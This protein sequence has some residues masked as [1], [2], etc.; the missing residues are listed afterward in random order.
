MKIRYKCTL[1]IL[2]IL[3]TGCGKNKSDEIKQDISMLDDDVN[4]GTDAVEDKSSDIPENLNYEVVGTNGAITVSVEAYVEAEGYG[5]ADVYS[6]KP[7][8]INSE[9]LMSF[10]KKIFDDETY[11]SIKPYVCMDKDELS[12]EKEFWESCSDMAGEEYDTYTD[13]YIRDKK[14]DIL[15][16]FLSA[17]GEYSD[18]WKQD[19]VI[20]IHELTD[21]DSNEGASYVNNANLRGFI[22]GTVYEL[23]YNAADGFE[24]PILE[25]VNPLYDN[26]DEILRFI[27]HKHSYTIYGNNPV[28][29]ETAKNDAD[30]F[31]YKLGYE[32]M[33]LVR[34]ANIQ[35]NDTTLDGYL[36]VYTRNKN[37]VSSIDSKCYTQIDGYDRA[38][39]QEYIEIYVNEYG[40]MCA[41]LMNIYELG[42]IMGESTPLLS[43]EQI[44]EN[45]KEYI[46]AGIDNE[47]YFYKINKVKFGY[48]SVCYGNS[49]ALIPAWVYQYYEDTFDDYYYEIAINAIDG[50]LINMEYA[51]YLNFY[52]D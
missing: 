39:Y 7:V 32:D 16:S 40:I 21:G 1:V 37:G 5:N 30:D 25:L 26:R 4:T 51:E 24:T 47:D 28:D 23:T 29:Y 44:D 35:L 10:A 11:Y 38:G 41:K 8:E 42:E 19:G 18:G 22:D 2:A 46:K 15:D 43:F 36:F 27:S 13:K 14:L 31:I 48:I 50:G 52:A 9:Y 3:L 20:W 17:A 45:A 33:A 34:S 49:Y 6:E 12:D